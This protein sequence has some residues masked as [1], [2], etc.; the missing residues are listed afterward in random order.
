[1]VLAIKMYSFYFI[2]EYGEF[3]HCKGEI[4]D[5]FEEIRKDIEVDTDRITG[6]NKGISKLYP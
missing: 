5:N 2:P 1:M 4:F 3:L 6:A